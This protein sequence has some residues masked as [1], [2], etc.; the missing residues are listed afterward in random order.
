MWFILQP[1]DDPEH[2]MFIQAKPGSKFKYRRKHYNVDA[3]IGTPVGSVFELQG[4][5]LRLV[6]LKTRA[7]VDDIRRSGELAAAAANK[8]GKVHSDNRHL[9]DDNTAQKMNQT[10]VQAMKDSGASAGEIMSS[11]VANS[12]TFQSKTEFSQAKYI[13]KKQRQYAPTFRTVP[14]CAQT[15]IDTM[16][17]KDSRRISGLRS[18][19]AA[20]LLSQSNVRAG[21][22]VLIVD[23]AMGVVVGGAAERMMGNGTIV[24]L[25][26][27]DHPNVTMLQRFNLPQEVEASVVHFPFNATHLLAESL[28]RP[29][30]HTENID[31][32]TWQQSKRIASIEQTRNLLSPHGADSFVAVVAEEYHALH[33]LRAVLPLLVPGAKLA[34]FCPFVEPLTEAALYLRKNNLAIDVSLTQLWVREF[35]VLPGR[36]R[37]SMNMNDGSGYVLSG[38]VVVEEEEEAG[39]SSSSSSSSASSSSSSSSSTSSSATTATATATT[40]T[41]TTATRKEPSSIPTS[42]NEPPTK[43]MKTT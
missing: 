12:T 29:L 15:I 2:R 11:L 43:R 31:F 30:D 5:N 16:H 37:P 25:I 35:Q 40:T 7:S 22:T 32:E 39:S 4:R 20:Q 41:T 27:G 28:H 42:T 3:I 24:N 1:L 21:S 14:C 26:L 23:S 8:S 34:M 10:D 13:K 6:D 17:N 9:V 36:T 18:D 33:I 19:G 38:T